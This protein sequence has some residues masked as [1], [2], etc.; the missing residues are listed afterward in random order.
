MRGTDSEYLLRARSP[1]PT[2]SPPGRGSR[3][4]CAG[5]FISDSEHQERRGAPDHHTGS[6]L[7]STA[8][9]MQGSLPRTLHE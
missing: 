9:T 2:L 8:A 1:Y 5:S 6:A 7:T 4:P 3:T